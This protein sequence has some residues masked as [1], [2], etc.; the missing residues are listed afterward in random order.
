MELVKTFMFLFLVNFA[1]A[2]NTTIYA[3]F[4]VYEREHKIK[5]I[6][7]VMGMRTLPYWFGTFIFDFLLINSINII[8]LALVYIFEI[9]KLMSQIFLFAGIIL[10][11]SVALLTSSYLWGF[12]F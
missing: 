3:A 1:Y 2:L 4:T 12:L 9:E 11:Y 10:P 5:Y 7:N 8:L 6:L